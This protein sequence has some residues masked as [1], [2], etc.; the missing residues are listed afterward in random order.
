METTTP[1]R[2]VSQPKRQVRFHRPTII[3]ISLA[4]AISFAALYQALAPAIEYQHY[5]SL[6]NAHAAETRGL[7]ALWGN[8]PLGHFALNAAFGLAAGLGYAGRAL[9]LFQVINSAI[10]G[11]TVAL[12]FVMALKLL[13]VDLASA[14]GVTLILG[15]SASFW[16]YAGT[17][18]IYSVAWLLALLAWIA[19]LYEVQRKQR[20]LPLWSG[21]LLGLAILAHQFNAVVALAGFFL[22][23]REQGF[24][25]GWPSSLSLLLIA[26]LITVLGYWGFG[27][28][29][30]GSGSLPAIMD[31]ITGHF[32]NP[33]YGRF[34]RLDSLP[35]AWMGAS[36]AILR[37]SWSL[38]S[39]LIR[40]A[41]LASLAGVMLLGLANYRAL[42]RQ[43]R[44]ALGAAVL[45]LAVAA[46]LIFWWEPYNLKFWLLALLPW[47]IILACSAAAA[48]P[49]LAGLLPAAH[50][51]HAG[52]I[53]GGVLVSISVL[54]LLFNLVFGV[55]SRS[56]P[57]QNYQQAMQAWLDHS[58]PNDVLITA[59]D[60]VPHL[61][62]WENRPHTVNL[63]SSLLASR[64]S[65]DPFSDLKQR[66]ETALCRGDSVFITPRASDAMPES[67][68]SILA[69][70]RSNLH[71]F[72]TSYTQEEAFSYPS[73]TLDAEVQVYRVAGGVQCA[74]Q[75]ITE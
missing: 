60:L 37:M 73:E 20:R 65:T 45:Q 22:I 40:I 49:R 36:G 6:I 39:Q 57:S 10:A 12:F 34:F 3:A 7:Q 46:L 72:L 44:S 21:I 28:I 27:M 64:Q 13:R 43:Q 33:T 26:S 23:L 1:D 52:A 5:D 31:W 30:T 67:W 55:I 48:R 24:R 42:S 38:R 35:D 47:A 54:M 25:R 17:A 53:L 58:S 18:D 19:V 61:L 9:P 66:I 2:T 29:A 11:A 74:Q 59:G 51:R 68:L 41:I 56:R 8:H 62:F 75:M 14:V 15:V 4:F 71:Q 16:N 50:T 32:A 69:L 70:P 63:Y